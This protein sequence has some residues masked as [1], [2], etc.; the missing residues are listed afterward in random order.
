VGRNR[1]S[2]SSLDQDTIRAV[3]LLLAQVAARYNVS[4]AYLF[5]SRARGNFRVDSDADVAI[6]LRGPPG[7]FLDTKLD[8][9]D[10]AY[11]VLLETGIR[12]Q[13]LPR[14]GGGVGTPRDLLQPAIAR[15]H[16]P[17]GH[18]P[19]TAAELMAKAT[20]STA[21]MPSGRLP[22]PLPLLRP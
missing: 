21:G 3:S 14:L 15:E 8:L 18:P 13:P 19:M 20:R 2:H 12:I 11:D 9:A 16:Q 7:A 5:G 1:R 17:R 6:L 22:R 10:I 4:D